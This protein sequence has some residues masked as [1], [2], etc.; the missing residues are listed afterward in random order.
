MSA[1]HVYDDA[2]EVEAVVDNDDADELEAEAPEV[3]ADAE[4]DHE[5]EEVMATVVEDDDDEEEEGNEGA[6]VLE[7]AVVEPEPAP[8]PT[9]KKASSKKKGNKKK[10]K[11]KRKMDDELYETVPPERVEAASDARAMLEDTVPTLPVAVA[12]TEVRSFGRLLIEPDME[13][14]K[15]ATT[16]ALYPV[17]FSCDRYEFSPV[18]GRILKLRCSILS[19]RQIKEKQQAAG[20][21][22]SKVHDGPVFRIM[23]G[24]GVDED[25]DQAEYP[26]DPYT[27][28]SPMHSDTD[29]TLP[30]QLSNLVPEPGMRVKVRFDKNQ[31]FYGSIIDIGEPESK[32]RRKQVEITIQYD[33][34][35]SESLL[36]PDP[37]VAIAM[38]GTCLSTCSEMDFYND[39]F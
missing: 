3:V 14:S 35:S 2:M 34:G 1:E 10:T 6:E 33:D 11:K 39:R 28:A 12:E 4:D 31:F 29:A 24:Q 32:K 5:D 8:Q 23:W 19:G 21:P 13:A 20:H 7:A 22:V 18:H 37:D 25:A 15:Y 30:T 26:F 9:K 38:P 16:S 17:G 36:F 27:H